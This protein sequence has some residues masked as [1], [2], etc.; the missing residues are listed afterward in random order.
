MNMAAEGPPTLILDRRISLS[1]A[2]SVSWGRRRIALSEAAVTRARE[3]FARLQTALAETRHVYGLTTGFGPLANR[4]VTPENGERLQ[5]NLVFHLASGVGD[6]FPWQVARAIVLARLMAL[7]QGA[8]GARPETVD[9]LVALLN[10]G[11]APAIPMRGTV[12]ASGDLTP[13]AHVVL[14]FQGHGHFVNQDGRRVTA[15]QALAD[16]GLTPLDLSHRD[17]LALVNG[18]SAMTGVA[19][20]NTLRLERALTWSVTL[21]GGL[22]EALGG[23]TEAWHR[24][25]A[26]L[27]PHPGQVRATER[28][29]RA[30]KGSGRVR[31]TP[32]AA[33]RLSG[34]SA[35]TQEDEAGQ[36]AYSL[37]CAPQ[38]IG[39]VWDTA[40]WHRRV[41]ETELHAVTDNPIF[42]A[43]LPEIALHGGNFMG[44]H[45]ALAA[46]AAANAAT[47]LAG[48][49]ERQIARITDEKLNRGL[50]AFLSGGLVGLTSGLMGAQVTATA[51]TAEMRLAGAASVQSISTNGAN[52]DVVSQGTIAARMLSD[53]I[54]LLFKVQAIAALSVAQALELLQRQDGGADLSPAA[55]DLIGF[56]RKTSPFLDEDRPLGGEIDTLASRMEA[57]QA[58]AGTQ[59]EVGRD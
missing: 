49:H 13:L 25:F 42:P 20:L 21:T 8:S 2:G 9:R 3:S 56:V 45:V 30:T 38:I 51:L 50:P 22:A 26:K 41:T 28:L 6:A 23:R 1:D 12:G 17:G 39:A 59:G 32:L 34:T 15:S 36:E 27:R 44:V 54:D 10:S 7:L 48:F 46:D 52:Q 29:L 5:Q 53:K 18:T 57:G 37:R 43:D 19:L 47:V 16:I 55:E 11:L 31:D 24:A 35:V 33:R 4:L 58:N 14:C 40:D